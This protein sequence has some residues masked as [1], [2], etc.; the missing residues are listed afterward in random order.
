M[1]K[2]ILAVLSMAVVLGLASTTFAAKGPVVTPKSCSI[3][4]RTND[5]P[6]IMQTRYLDGGYSLKALRK[7]LGLS[8]EQMNEMRLLYTDFASRAKDSRKS[9]VSLLNEKRAM[10]KSGNIDQK[11]LNDID[12]QLVSL[13]SDI[14][15]DRLKLIRD[16]LALLTP[17][18]IRKLG[19]KKVM[20]ASAT[21]KKRAKRILQACVCK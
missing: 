3:V 14:F 21:K 12:G 19:K 17:D 11:K 10:L 16:R 2:I 15:R 9:V 4:I 7:K 18:Q 6:S 1:N 13:R 5:G 8:K 20:T